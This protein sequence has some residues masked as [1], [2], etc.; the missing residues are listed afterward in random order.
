MAG[1]GSCARSS[2]CIGCAIRLEL[3][4]PRARCATQA[5][6]EVLRWGP[7]HRGDRV[8]REVPCSKA[9]LKNRFLA[10]PKQKSPGLP[11]VASNRTWVA[12]E[13][14]QWSNPHLKDFSLFNVRVAVVSRP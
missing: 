5:K 9:V 14:T 13:R 7:D 4:C 6:E 8:A 3:A 1:H 12:A 11:W 2:L 10:C